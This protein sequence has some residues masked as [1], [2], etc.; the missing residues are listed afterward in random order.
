MA[1]KGWVGHQ[2]DPV[3]SLAEQLR[4]LAPQLTLTALTCSPSV[5]H[6]LHPP[7]RPAEEEELP[8]PSKGGK[9]GAKGS[10]AKAAPA[11]EPVDPAK[12][13]GCIYIAVFVQTAVFVQPAASCPYARLAGQRIPSCSCP[14]CLLIAPQPCWMAP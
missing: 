9:G 1:Q 7:A 2:D 4:W 8:P 10:K 11:P 6:C 14:E 13:V 12:K 5:S 3:W